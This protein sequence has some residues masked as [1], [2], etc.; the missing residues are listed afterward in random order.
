MNV[1]P[2][3]KLFVLSLH[4]QQIQLFGGPDGLIN[5]P[6]LDSAL[7]QPFASFSGEDLYPTIEEKA[8][9][10]AFGIIKNHPFADGNKRTGAAAMVAFLKINGY[11]LKPSHKE[12]ENV[13]FGIASGESDFIDLVG[14]ISKAVLSEVR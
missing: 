9:R 13:I 8:A 1:I 10:Y 3:S 12:F 4:H 7:S 14:F 11:D 6:L 2:L 5:A